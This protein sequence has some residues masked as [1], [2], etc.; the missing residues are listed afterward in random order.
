M[1]EGVGAFR[2]FREMIHASEVLQSTGGC[3][4]I[5]LTRCVDVYTFTVDMGR[6]RKSEDHKR[7]KL[8]PLRLSPRE[9]KFFSRKARA[10][11]ESVASIFRNGGMLYIQTRS[12]DGSQK[13]KENKQ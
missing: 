2:E 7:S 9:A 4:L 8:F 13:R 1:V 3:L 12:K 10:L 6:P 11:G 5:C